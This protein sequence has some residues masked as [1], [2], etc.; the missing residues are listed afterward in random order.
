ML[1]PR[2]ALQDTVQSFAPPGSVGPV[3]LFEIQRGP[4]LPPRGT[5]DRDRVLR[6]YDTHDY[7]A[8]W[9]GAR[10]GI[11]KKVASLPFVLNGPT[12]KIQYWQDM[13]GQAHFGH[14]WEYLLKLIIRDFLTQSYGGIFEIAGPGDPMKPLLEAPTGINHLDAG[15]CYVTGN[16]IYPVLY[17]S[18]WDGKLHRMHASRVYMMVD[19]PVA[20]ERYFGIGT[21]ALERAIALCNREIRMAQYIDVKLDDKPKPGILALTGV[22]DK[23][24]EARI[25]AYIASLQAGDNLPMF[26]RTLVLS[27]LDPNAKVGAESIPFSQT[28]ELFDFTKY[29]DTDVDSFALAIGVDRQEL[30]QLSGGKAMG[31]AAQSETLALK[32]RGKL[33]ADLITGIERFVNW[34][35]LPDDCEFKIEEQD[36]Q[37]DTRQA[38]LDLQYV[39]IGQALMAMGFKQEA[40]AQLLSQQSKTFRD[41]FSNDFGQVQATGNVQGVTPDAPSQDANLESDTPAPDQAQAKPQVMA[42]TAKEAQAYKFNPNHESDTGQFAHGSGGGRGAGSNDRPGRSRS[43]VETSGGNRPAST[44]TYDESFNGDSQVYQRQVRAQSKKWSKELNPTEHHAVSDYATFDYNDMN[45]V[46]RGK[47]S[48]GQARDPEHMKQNITALDSAVKKGKLDKNR[49]L[50]RGI[51]SAQL[52]SK[53]KAGDTF[54]DKAFASTTLD[55]KIAVGF[56]QGKGALI[57]IKAKKGQSGAYLSEMSPA[58]GEAEFL[59]PRNSKFKVTKITKEGSRTIIDMDLIGDDNG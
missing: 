36:T 28:P 7:N 5:K 14:G 33:Y 1:P 10:S 54:T 35:L 51:S 34:A 46:L 17:Y 32:S 4:I 9:Q 49:V 38:T 42:Q 21:S 27:S 6:I 58:P 15:R 31:T 29:T 40:V 30:W 24:W 22:S 41:A 53:L 48:T 52:I 47:R 11:T 37:E 18:L 55:K 43:D 19:D 56:T 45:S 25:A 23:Q 20:D 44:E 8:L 2:Q 39:Q 50:Y 26:G 16:P 59:L 13:F 57:R 12:A 3:L